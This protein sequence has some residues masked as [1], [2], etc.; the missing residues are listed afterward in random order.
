MKSS[1]S[2]A[3]LCSI[4]ALSLGACKKGPDVPM[5]ETNCRITSFTY[6]IPLN[7]TP[8]SGIV[9]YNNDGNP[10][11]VKISPVFTASPHATFFY[12]KHKRLTDHIGVYGAQ[13]DPSNL[14]DKITFE[15]WVRFIYADE[16]PSSLPIGDTLYVI[17]NYTKGGPILA[18]STTI[19]SFVYDAQGR[20]I[21]VT[22]SS[23][24][25]TR[26]YTYD[27]NGNLVLPNVVY[28]TRK[29]PRQTNKVWM[30]VDKNF[31]KNNPVVATQYNAEGFPTLF[32]APDPQHYPDDFVR[33]SVV[34]KTIDYDCAT[35]KQPVK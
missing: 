14:P 9:S 21:Q 27:A 24:F 15:Y 6:T 23:N 4:V 1:F 31:S 20:I 25:P 18:S 11:A 26:T 8:Y 12:D 7:S 29:N 28:D 19:E 5:P 13:T 16:N 30:L 34:F 2:I 3:I 35:A 10:S 32:P 17:G 33:R 22:A